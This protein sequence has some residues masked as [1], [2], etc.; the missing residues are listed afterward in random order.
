MVLF[1]GRFGPQLECK[2]G[3]FLQGL[4]CK[5]DGLQGC[6]VQGLY[7]MRAMSCKVLQALQKV[8]QGKG[9]HEVDTLQNI[10]DEQVEKTAGFLHS[11]FCKA[12]KGGHQVDTELP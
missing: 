3:L 12:P 5:A 8:L 1:T 4:V 9:G 11:L 2:E 10:S 6:V 7:F